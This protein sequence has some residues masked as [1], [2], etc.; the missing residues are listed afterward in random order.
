MEWLAGLPDHAEFVYLVI[1]GRRGW[2]SRIY[3]FGTFVS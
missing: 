3:V 1:F 2:Y